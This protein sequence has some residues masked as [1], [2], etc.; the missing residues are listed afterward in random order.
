MKPGTVYV[1][2]VANRYLQLSWLD[3]RTGKERRRS[4]KTNV[5]RE[6]LSAANKIERTL[7]R[8]IDL[9]S[10]PWWDFCDRYE[11]EHIATLKPSSQKDWPT[12][13]DSASGILHPDLLSELT[14][15]RFS[16]IF[17][18]PVNR[19]KVLLRYLIDTTAIPVVEI[20]R[21]SKKLPV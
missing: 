9:Q 4:A 1:K 8:G 21:A 15:S 20:G 3:P 14:A 19:Q 16:D 12:A 18:K 13:R 11:A 7:S 6:A 10:I 5:L 17:L 2:K